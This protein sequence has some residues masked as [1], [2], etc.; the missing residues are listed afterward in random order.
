[1]NYM[2]AVLSSGNL[3]AARPQRVQPRDKQSPFDEYGKITKDIERAFGSYSSDEREVR[4]WEM[5]PGNN[6]VGHRDGF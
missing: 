1:M 4:Q 2:L 6:C 5:G 3:E